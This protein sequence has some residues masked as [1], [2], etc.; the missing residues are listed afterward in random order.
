MNGDFLV[1]CIPLPVIK[2]IPVTPA[3]SPEKQYIV[4]TS[5]LV[6]IPFLYFEAESKFWLDDGFKAINMEFEHPDISS[7]WQ[8]TNEVDTSRIILKAYGLGGLSSQRVLAA[9]RKVYPGKRDTIV[10]ALTV[11]WT[12]DKY[13]PT[14][15]ME[16]FP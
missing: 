13:A 11:D 10:Q 9:F 1:N 7:I 14:C 3:L 12:T 8:E 15:E 5:R 2:N 6:L 4:D 16:A